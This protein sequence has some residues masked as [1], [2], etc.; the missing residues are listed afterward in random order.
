MTLSRKDILN[1]DY[2][3]PDSLIKLKPTR[4]FQQRI[5]ERDGGLSCLPS[6]VRV[7]KDNIHSGKTKDGIHLNSVVVRLKYT[8]DKFL[9][10][11]LNPY[12][13]GA[14]SFWFRKIEKNETKE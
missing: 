4:H 14:K 6:Y 7:T 10:I 1:G 9:F 2:K 5:K 3:Y 13:G 11:A 12:D 8:S